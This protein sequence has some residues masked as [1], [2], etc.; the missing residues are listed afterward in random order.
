MKKCSKSDNSVKCYEYFDNN[1]NFVIIM[2]LC[3]V[4][5][6]QLLMKNLEKYD[7][8]FSVE[9][10]YEIMMQLNNALKIMKNNN[11]IHR[12]LK[13][14]NILIKYIEN[15][16]YIIKLADYG[17]SKRLDSLSKNYC[18]SKVGTLIYMAP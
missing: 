12:D 2:E 11:I 17:S 9:E 14:E 6:S 15:N 16:K 18:N 1:K 3:D 13:L 4:N 10:I 8:G 7:R 5:L